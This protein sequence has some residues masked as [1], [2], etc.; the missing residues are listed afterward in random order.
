MGY[1][2]VADSVVELVDNKTTLCYWNHSNKVTAQ[3]Q[4]F[5]QWRRKG[6]IPLN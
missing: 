2:F 1:K 4:G 5:I 6:E 3:L